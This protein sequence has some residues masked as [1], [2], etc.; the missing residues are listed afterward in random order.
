[1]ATGDKIFNWI[2]ERVNEGRTV[3]AT[4]YLRSLKIQKKHVDAGMVRVRDGHCEV[5]RGKAWDSINLCKIT[6]R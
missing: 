6:A 4:T 5:Q 2:S 3:Y 1:M